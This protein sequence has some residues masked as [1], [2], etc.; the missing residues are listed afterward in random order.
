M[1]Y[2]FRIFFTV[3]ILIAILVE[4]EHINPR[5][6][7]ISLGLMLIGSISMLIEMDKEKL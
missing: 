1:I 2:L 7:N 4:L 6:I 5:Y 3:S